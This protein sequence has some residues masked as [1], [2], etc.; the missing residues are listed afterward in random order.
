MTD[1]NMTPAAAP[2]SDLIAT[3]ARTRKRNAAEKRFRFYGMAAIGVGV[4]FLLFLFASIL[5][6]GLPAFSQTCLLY[7]SPSP[8]DRG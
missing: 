1:T 4:L 3:D 2:K 6:S 8:R 5:R 7:T